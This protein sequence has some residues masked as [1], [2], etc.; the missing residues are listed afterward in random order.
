MGQIG[1][2][3]WLN[4]KISA[5]GVGEQCAHVR[6]VFCCERIWRTFGDGKANDGLGWCTYQ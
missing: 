2:E 3:R 5:F 6:Q 1:H 4:A